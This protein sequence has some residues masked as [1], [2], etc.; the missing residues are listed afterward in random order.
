MTRAHFY[1]YLLDEEGRPIPGATVEVREPGTTTKISETIYA[2]DD[3]SATTKT[4]PFSAAADGLCEVWLTNPKVVDLYITKTGYDPQTRRATVHQLTASTLTFKDDGAANPQRAGVNFQDGF[5]LTDDAAGDEVEVDLDYGGTTELADVADTEA[6]GTS[7]KV[8]RADHV[9]AHPV[10]ASGD[11]HGEYVQEAVHTKAAHDSMALSHDSLAD[12]SANDHHAQ[13]HAHSGADGSGT[14]AHSATTGRTTDDHH[15]KQHALS[16]ADHTGEIS[17]TQHGV[18]TLA[19]AHSH[20]DLSGVSINDHHDRDHD[21]RNHTFIGAQA[22]KGSDQGSIASGIA[23]PVQVTLNTA[24]I[25]S[26]SIFVSGTNSFDIPYAGVWRVRFKAIF[27]APS[28]N[29]EIRAIIK[30]DGS[31][32]TSSMERAATSGGDRNSVETEALFDCAGGEVFTFWVAHND[33]SPM[34]TAGGTVLS[35][36]CFAE[37]EYLGA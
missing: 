34:T 3:P 2:A 21:D 14:V 17:D 35:N 37:C 20:D 11:L 26:S 12:V 5:V 16:G 18:R 9:H 28:G 25:D 23:T 27:N 1:T 15:N 13:S 8:A 6:A 10:F 30:K 33:G 29:C 32:V 22:T 31:E 19:N 7:S 36:S 4:N 24:T